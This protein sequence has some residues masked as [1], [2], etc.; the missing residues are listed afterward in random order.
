MSPSKH[1]TPRD[2]LL[3]WLDLR[4]G[5]SRCEWAIDPD[6][7]VD[8]HD[9][10]VISRTGRTWHRV[11]YSGDDVAFRRACRS[12]FEQAEQAGQPVLL[13]VTRC[14]ENPESVDISHI[15]DILRSGRCT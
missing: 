12:T 11:L 4:P 2:L 3:K 6:R 9:P 14:S 5:Q 1:L 10:Q 15:C 8:W 7:L 13:V